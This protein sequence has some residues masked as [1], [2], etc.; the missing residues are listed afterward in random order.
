MVDNNSEIKKA[1]GL[2]KN[3][4]ATI[5]HDKYRDVLLNNKCLRLSMNR[6]SKD[7]RIGT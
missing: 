7:H 4:V 5:S 6:I 2:Y 3:V 1:K